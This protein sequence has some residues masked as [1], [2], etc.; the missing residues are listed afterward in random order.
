[1][2]FDLYNTDKAQ[3]YE[4]W[5]NRIHLV[6]SILEYDYFKLWDL[7]EVEFEILEEFATKELEGRKARIEEISSKRGQ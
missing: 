4:Y 6:A 5:V 7:P 3:E 1:M 2:L